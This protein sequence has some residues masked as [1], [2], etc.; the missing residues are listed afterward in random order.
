GRTGVR[1]VLVVAV[2]VATVVTA[3]AGDRER[4]ARLRVGQLR[5]ATVERGRGGDGV[6]A[7]LQGL[8]RGERPVAVVVDVELTGPRR[9]VVVRVV[10]ETKPLVGAVR[11]GRNEQQLDRGAGEGGAFEG[12]VTGDGR[13]V[14]G[15]GDGHVVGLDAE[16]GNGGLLRVVLELL[17]DDGVEANAHRQVGVRRD[18]PGAV[19]GDLGL[20]VGLVADG[21]RDRGA[22]LAGAGEVRTGVTGGLAVSGGVDDQL[23]DLGL[24]ADH[25]RTAVGV[26]G[27]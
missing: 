11:T 23:G 16:V 20:T 6:V 12:D 2:L 19:L 8:V 3:A 18:G 26:G 17:R 5:V 27:R 10:L 1:Q 7:V 14:L 21:Q 9:G 15:G 4:R 24:F 13:A 22:G 25:E